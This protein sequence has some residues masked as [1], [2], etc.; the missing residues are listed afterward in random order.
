MVERLLADVPTSVWTN[1]AMIGSAVSI[2]GSPDS[3]VLKGCSTGT[4]VST[5]SAWTGEWD[6]LSVFEGSGLVTRCRYAREIQPPS[7]TDSIS[8]SYSQS[9]T[10]VGVGGRAHY[11]ERQ[12]SGLIV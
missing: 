3:R 4:G 2:D 6:A 1:A 11:Y 8:H 5:P 7:V 10:L 12:F 9:L